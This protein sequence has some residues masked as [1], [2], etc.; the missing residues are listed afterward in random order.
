[1]S[2]IRVKNFGPIKSGLQ[3]NDFI[4]MDKVSLLI[5]NQAT[6]K[7]SVAKLFSTLTW[8]EKSLTNGDLKS[9]FVAEHKRFIKTYCAYQGINNY[10]KKNTS[11]EYIGKSYHF[12]YKNEKLEILYNK[13]NEAYLTPKLMYIP[14]ERNF[15]SVIEKLQR[16]EGLP[17]ALYTFLDEFELS[18]SSLNNSI[19]LPI[20]N[21]EFEY[22]KQN[23]ISYIKNND[24]K[25]R[26][27]EASSGIQS[28]LPVFLVSRN[29]ANSIIEKK[30]N[31][32]KQISVEKE[33]RIKQE[34]RTILSNSKLSEEMKTILLERLSNIHQNLCFI[35]IVEEIEQNLFP[36]SQRNLL[37][38]LLALNNLS[39]GNKL[40]L[41]SHS[42]Y[43][44][45][46]LTLV[47]KANAIKEQ[48]NLNLLDKKLINKIENIVPFK[49][50][51]SSKQVNIYEFSDKG[52]IILLPNYDGIPS[53]SNYLNESLFETNEL[54]DKLLEIEDA[55]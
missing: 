23:K 3:N 9:N 26:L 45:N 42:P 14:A 38:E 15:L 55:I 40:I 11:I 19:R 13:K 24:F 37:Y 47:I 39:E 5:G 7:S 50:C 34:I 4:V 17:K 33:R 25:L 16:V 43:I 21:I 31:T 53:D 44:L 22:Q 41:T 29:L 1:M 49:S 20:N 36:T 30:D 18:K 35:N 32:I 54:F 12:I 51:V 52:E 28:L 10:F 46:Y 8:L 48:T 27:H 6:G 2:K